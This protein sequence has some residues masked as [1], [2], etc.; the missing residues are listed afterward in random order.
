MDELTPAALGELQRL[1]KEVGTPSPD[2]TAFQVLWEQRLVMG[3]HQKCHITARG[4][5]LLER[6]QA[7]KSTS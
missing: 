6:L 7:T 3:T 4:K 5:Q 1:A 2:D